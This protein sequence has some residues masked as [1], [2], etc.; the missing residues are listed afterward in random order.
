MI[1]LV[2]YDRARGQLVS[3]AVFA[4]TE[5]AAAHRARLELE[6]QLNKS[7]VDHEVVLLD[8]VSEEA[9]RRNHERYFQAVEDF[10]VPEENS[11]VPVR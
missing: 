4:D 3:K 5:R 7:G 11:P 10:P 8:A 9:L 1:F 2:R 6:L